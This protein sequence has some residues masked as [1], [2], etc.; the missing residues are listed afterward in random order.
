MNVVSTDFSP[1]I[2]DFEKFFTLWAQGSNLESQNVQI[3][4]RLIN[5]PCHNEKLFFQSCQLLYNFFGIWKKERF[6]PRVRNSAHVDNTF[7]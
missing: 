3:V 6:Y 2:L 1:R 7:N 4:E 5:F